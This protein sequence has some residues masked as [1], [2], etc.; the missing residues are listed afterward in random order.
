MSKLS[1]QIRKKQWYIDNY[2]VHVARSKKWVETNKF[3]AKLN[4][5]KYYWKV[6][7]VNRKEKRE[8]SLEKKW[9]NG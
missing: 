1:E 4:R 9:S 3:R 2:I 7:K 5:Q 6:E 8:K